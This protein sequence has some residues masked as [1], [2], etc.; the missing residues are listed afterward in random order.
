MIQTLRQAERL[1]LGLRIGPIRMNW[2]LSGQ[3][4]L[5]FILSGCSRQ[6]LLPFV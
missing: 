5:D 6:Q 3:L 1:I 4:R 2:A